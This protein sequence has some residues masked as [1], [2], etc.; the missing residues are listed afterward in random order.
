[1]GRFNLRTP[2]LTMAREQIRA[3][4]WY[5]VRAIIFASF[6]LAVQRSAVD[7][8]PVVCWPSQPSWWDAIRY[9]PPLGTLPRIKKKEV[10]KL[11]FL[12]DRLIR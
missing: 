3:G 9:V 7:E 2:F 4:V 11:H 6:S 12:E 1:M 10:P 5:K 8:V